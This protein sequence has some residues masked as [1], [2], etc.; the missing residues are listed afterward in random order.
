MTDFAWETFR[1]RGNYIDGSFRVPNDP[2]GVIRSTNPA[3]P[4]DVV[5]EFPWR[6]DAIDEAAFAA[7]KA[8]DAW[9]RASFEERAS[10]LRRYEKA[11]EKN[12]ERLAQAISREMGKVLW[13]ARTEAKAVASKVPITLEDS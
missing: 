7:R 4:D 5:G 8:F 3:D 13:E 11:V 9:S 10:C 1:V 2:E 12:A 6:A